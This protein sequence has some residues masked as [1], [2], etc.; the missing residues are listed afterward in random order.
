MVG[1]VRLPSFCVCAPSEKA[2]ATCLREMPV[3]SRVDPNTHT[4]RERNV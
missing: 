1:D 2:A 4:H 3:A